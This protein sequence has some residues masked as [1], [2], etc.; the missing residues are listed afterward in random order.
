[1]KW[2]IR[3]I[4]DES[5]PEPHQRSPRGSASADRVF[6]VGRIMHTEGTAPL[7]LS[8]FPNPE[9]RPAQQPEPPETPR[10][11]PDQADTNRARPES[12]QFQKDRPD[13]APRTAPMSR[14]RDAFLTHESP[15]VC[16]QA[17]RPDLAA[18]EP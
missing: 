9:H 1:M 8:R 16:S 13:R 11:T 15:P 6:V 2:P 14:K 17:L 4:P 18:R 12:G 3:C 10:G 5:R 7:L